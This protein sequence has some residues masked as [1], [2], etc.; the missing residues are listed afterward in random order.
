[1]NPLIPLALLGGGYYLYDRH[2]KR[3]AFQAKPTGGPAG[4][5][6]PKPPLEA[7][8]GVWDPDW[9]EVGASETD[10]VKSQRRAKMAGRGQDE[11]LI[12]D[13][14]GVTFLT[15]YP[16]F[17]GAYLFK[18]SIEVATA[19]PMPV[20]PAALFDQRA[21]LLNKAFPRWEA[22]WLRIELDQVAAGV[23]VFIPDWTPPAL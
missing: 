3:L 9:V 20:V 19:V 21:A 7:S 18:T 13:I 1:M 4:H 2:Q 10:K 6:P 5:A 16:E 12:R 22:E 17:P 23:I 14:L 8:A 11:A 15:S